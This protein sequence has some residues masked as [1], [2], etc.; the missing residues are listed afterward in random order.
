MSRPKYEVNEICK[1]DI[2]ARK[3][4]LCE[5]EWCL[6]QM[7]LERDAARADAQSVRD[8]ILHHKS[9]CNC[10]EPNEKMQKTLDRIGSWPRKQ[11]GPA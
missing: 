6:S 8:A 2:L 7:T 1:H 4:E 10:I 11:I 3:C 9:E 5:L